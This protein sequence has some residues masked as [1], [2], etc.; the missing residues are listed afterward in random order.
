MDW[1][2]VCSTSELSSSGTYSSDGREA[3]DEQS[4]WVGPV[5]EGH[6][7]NFPLPHTLARQ[8]RFIK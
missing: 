2:G 5:D 6:N 8:Q 1:D 4:D 3:D 7:S